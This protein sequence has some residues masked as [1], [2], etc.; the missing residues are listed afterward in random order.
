MRWNARP[1][2]TERSQKG[3]KTTMICP[4]KNFIFI[5]IPKTA[6]RSVR[7]G[8]RPYCYS[9]AQEIKRLAD[10][11]TVPLGMKCSE[12]PKNRFS[13]LRGHPLGHEYVDELGDDFFKYYRF[14]FVRNPYDRMISYYS[15]KIR[16]NAIDQS[17]N[18]S[19][20]VLSTIEEKDFLPQADFIRDRTGAPLVN[21]VGRVETISEDFN[22]IAQKIGI[23]SKIPHKNEAP[24]SKQ[25][26][27]DSQTK[28]LFDDFYGE[29]LE[30]FGY[31][32]EDH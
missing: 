14:T 24:R 17:T 25:K 1:N 26:Y 32:Y 19:S 20:F 23:P 3:K 10:L 16:N 28:K 22:V 8:L 15:W 5:H 29:D 2:G 21:Y 9:K 6:G 12:F 13:N 11:I 31:T 18:F 30:Y 4:K 27:F 7:S